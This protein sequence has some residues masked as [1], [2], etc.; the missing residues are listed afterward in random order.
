MI[1]YKNQPQTFLIKR[2]AFQETW[3]V[4]TLGQSHDMWL[5]DLREWL[6]LRNAD[7]VA[8]ENA[9][10]EAYHFRE[11]VLVVKSPRKIRSSTGIDDPQLD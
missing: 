4:T 3:T 9:L 11:S 10:D 7:E 8:M 1:D 2:E 5:E 6:L